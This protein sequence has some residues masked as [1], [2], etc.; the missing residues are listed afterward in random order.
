MTI[1]ELLECSP[2]PEG[3]EGLLE[4][5]ALPPGEAER[6][7][8]LALAGAGLPPVEKKEE[9]TMKKR[10]MA[11]LLMAGV[12]CAGAVVANWGPRGTRSRGWGAPPSRPPGSRR[13]GP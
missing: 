7:L 8:A 9:G 10:N 11:L 12:L 13:A 3:T 2:L 6:V 1:R 5:G 4:P